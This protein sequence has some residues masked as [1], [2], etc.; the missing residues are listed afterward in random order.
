MWLFSLWLA[1]FS[2][3][4]VAQPP[5]IT[6]Q[7]GNTL[8]SFDDTVPLGFLEYAANP[9]PA[10]ETTRY[11]DHKTKREKSA[12]FKTY[13]TVDIDKAPSQYLFTFEDMVWTAAM[14]EGETDC[15][16]DA[17]SAA[18]LWTMVQRG[19]LYPKAKPSD[20]VSFGEHL[21]HYSVA[22]DPNFTS[23]GRECVGKHSGNCAPKTVE[24][25]EERLKRVQSML[26]RH[27][28]AG[29]EKVTFRRACKSIAYRFLSGHL[30]NP[31]PGAVEF[32]AFCKLPKEKAERQEYQF[33]A[34][35][36]DGSGKK[37]SSGSRFRCPPTPSR[38]GDGDRLYGGDL[39]YSRHILHTDQ[40]I[41]ISTH[42][43]TGNEVQIHAQEHNSVARKTEPRPS[44]ESH[45]S[46]DHQQISILEENSRPSD[47]DDSPG[48]QAD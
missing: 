14:L 1:F 27:T 20:E 45:M 5:E 37:V 30:R 29:P 25:R 24:A 46:E 16:D 21:Q 22:I 38:N 36:K 42:D 9:K 40:K 19:A 32:A 39:F 33:I 4:A 11:I 7:D 48:A 3:T 10:I 8:E 13:K 15:T 2:L 28:W 35:F 31:V 44:R 18:V 6:D 26:S 43:W 23:G 17:H 47:P 41:K 34:M 12:A